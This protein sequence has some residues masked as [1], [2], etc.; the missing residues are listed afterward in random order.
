MVCPNLRSSHEGD[1]LVFA[2]EQKT[3]WFQLPRRRQTDLY[4]SVDNAVRNTMDQHIPSIQSRLRS[5]GVRDS[6]TCP[7]NGPVEQARGRR[8]LLQTS[9]E[10]QLPVDHADPTDRTII[11]VSLDKIIW[12]RRRLS[13]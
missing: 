12:W 5:S 10:A 7:S 1:T 4:R 3:L 11:V 2:V 9:W 13:K 6:S 8:G